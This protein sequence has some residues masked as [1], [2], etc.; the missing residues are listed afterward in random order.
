[1]ASLLPTAAAPLAGQRPGDPPPAAEALV[2]GETESRHCRVASAAFGPGPPLVLP[3]PGAGS[4]VSG[5]EEEERL[6]H[7]RGQGPARRCS[8]WGARPLCPSPATLPR[9]GSPR[10]L[11][12]WVTPLPEPPSI[13]VPSASAPSPWLWQAPTGVDPTRQPLH[14]W[15]GPG[16]ERGCWPQPSPRGG[17]PPAPALWGA[18]TPSAG[19]GSS[20]QQEGEQDASLNGNCRGNLRKANRETRTGLRDKHSCCRSGRQPRGPRQRPRSG[21]AVP[22]ARSLPCQGWHQCRWACAAPGLGL[23]AAVPCAPTAQICPRLRAPPPCSLR[24]AGGT[25]RCGTERGTARRS[26]ARHGTGYRS[27]LAVLGAPSWGQRSPRAHQ[28]WWHRR[29]PWVRGCSS[30]SGGDLWA[31]A[32][33]RGCRG[34]C[35][36]PGSSTRLWGGG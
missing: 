26:M 28:P 12:G 31:A 30:L 3:V 27:S 4:R 29:L 24:W 36:W 17:H 34:G 16:R 13:P 6:P 8:G 9:P 25:A 14:P 19:L 15:P 10:G 1:M 5:R 20:P 35:A 18:P 11:W 33:C 22:P 23:V 7:P 32:C 21:P 2:H